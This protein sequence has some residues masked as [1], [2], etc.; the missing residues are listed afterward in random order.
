M[1]GKVDRQP[2]GQYGRWARSLQAGPDRI[3]AKL[4]AAWCDAR[5]AKVIDQQGTGLTET[6][7]R[8]EGQRDVRQIDAGE[9]GGQVIPV[10]DRG[11]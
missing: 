3:G 8:I 1:A 6:A 10:Q 5:N 9:R 11:S 7:A 4:D 2:Q